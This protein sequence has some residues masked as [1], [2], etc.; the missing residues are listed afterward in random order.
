[1]PSG[2]YTRTE[3]HRKITS[4]GRKGI[5]LSKEHRRKISLSLID[6]TRAKGYIP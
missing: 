4:E 2:V 5:K 1:M 6:N 3:W